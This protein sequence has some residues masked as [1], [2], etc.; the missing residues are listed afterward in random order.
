MRLQDDSRGQIYTI[1]GIVASFILLS[2]LLFILQSNSIIVPQTE[3][4]IDMKLYEKASD[5]L[6]VLDRNDNDSW[7]TI[8]PLKT[9]VAGWNGAPGEAMMTCLDNN[10]SEK[11]MLPDQVEYNLIFVYNN[12]TALNSSTVIYHGIPTDNSVV[13]TR[14]VT[15]NDNDI[16]TGSSFWK[17]INATRHQPETIEVK[18]ICW[19]L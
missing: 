11:K 6:V 4:A 9:Y 16:S 1:E 2:V 8:Q 13:A 14:L 3:R 17:T 10:I 18:L 19:Y 12:S 5:T 15:L 7:S